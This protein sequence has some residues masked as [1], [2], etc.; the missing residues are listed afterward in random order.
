MAVIHE[1]TMNPTKVELLAAWLPR[2]PW[3]IGAGN[4]PALARTGGFRLD[5][6]AGEVGIEF[7]AGTDHSTDQ[8]VTYLMPMTYRGEPLPDGDDALIG[9]SQHGVLGKRWIYDGAWDLV[10]ITQLVAL[11]QGQADPQAQS[12][13]NTADPTVTSRPVANSPLAVTGSVVEVN[14]PAGTVLRV[15]TASADGMPGGQWLVRLVRLLEPDATTS[16]RDLAQPG[17][18]ATWRHLD[19]TTV[20]GVF[21]TACVADQPS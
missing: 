14:G 6:P 2:Q 12:V 10:L 17:V 21:A 3:F 7:F 19:G 11:I 20:R 8:P 15:H 4:G 13:T 16:S 18:S 5:D 9:T 1:T